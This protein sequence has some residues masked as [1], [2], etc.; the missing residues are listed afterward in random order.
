M[1]L[2]LIQKK[3]FHELASDGRQYDPTGGMGMSGD[4]KELVIRDVDESLQHWAKQVVL[5][6]FQEHFGFIDPSLNPDLNAITESYTKQGNVFLVGT[7]GSEVVCTGALVAVTD[8]LGR[9]VRMSVKNQYRRNGF[10]SK[11]I[12]RLEQIAAQR[13]YTSIMLKTKRHWSDAVGFYESRGYAIRSTEGDSVTMSKELGTENETMNIYMVRHAESP[14]SAELERT[15]GLSEQGWADAA[16]VAD[17]LMKESIDAVVSSPY[18]RAVQTVQGFAEKRGLPIERM[19][20]FRERDL[21]GPD[22]RFEGGFMEGIE[23]VFRDPDFQY[24]GGESNR[25]V[26]ERGIRAMNQVMEKYAGR[27]AAIGI[28]GNIMTIIMGSYDK[29]YDLDFWKT[30]SKPDIYKM[31]FESRRLVCVERLWGV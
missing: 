6:G 4:S 28:H 5:E 21:A 23:T 29:R 1:V 10:A 17:I 30:T 16:L 19:E 31:K 24:P 9:I 11:M 3:E 27:N 8:R 22:V 12:A 18:T 15:R 20:D 7:V 26:A 2:P 25:A 13:G 14:Y